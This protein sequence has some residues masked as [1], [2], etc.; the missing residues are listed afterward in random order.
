MESQHAPTGSPTV[1]P[2]PL[3]RLHPLITFFTLAYTIS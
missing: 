1:A 2:L 3:F